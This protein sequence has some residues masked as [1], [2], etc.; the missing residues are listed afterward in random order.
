MLDFPNFVIFFY[1][2]EL[3]GFTQEI[4]KLGSFDFSQGSDQ[5]VGHLNY[6][7]SSKVVNRNLS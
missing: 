2:L 1:N 5:F 3:A 4:K 6:S 7:G